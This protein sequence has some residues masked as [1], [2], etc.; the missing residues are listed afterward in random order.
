MG[1]DKL[2]VFIFLVGTGA[3]AVIGAMS[4]IGRRSR[5][6]WGVAALFGVGATVYWRFAT[7]GFGYMAFRT[8]WAL[9]P[10]TAVILCLLVVGDRE[11]RKRPLAKALTKPPTLNPALT[12][13]YLNGVVD[14]ATKL[15]AQRKLA[16]HSNQLAKIKGRADNVVEQQ[17]EVTVEVSG[18]GNEY[19]HPRR[20]S[21]RRDQADALE[22]IKRGDWIELSGRVQHST[23]YGWVLVECELVGRAAPP[24]NPRAPRKP[25][26]RKAP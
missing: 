23:V 18:I 3:A 24:P 12:V 13:E 16:T 15:E 22:I 25:R 5:L 11:P 26:A 7:T 4:T 17:N 14:G 20:M 10:V 6:L 19:D 1:G 9:M 21:F 8:G 2:T